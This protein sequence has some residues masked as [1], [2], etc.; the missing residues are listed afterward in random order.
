MVKNGPVALIPKKTKD[1][2]KK[3]ILGNSSTQDV[4]DGL[5]IGI[6][7]AFLPIIGI[8]MYVSFMLTTFLKKNWQIA[9]LSAWISNPFTFVPLYLFNYWVGT[10]F[11]NVSVSISEM[12]VALKNWNW[13][14]IASMSLEVL[15]PLFLG[16]AIVGIV[17]AFISRALCLK[18]YPAIKE[19]YLKKY[20]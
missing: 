5:A 12:E 20:S 13:E 2:F 19:K 10:W 16:S 3:L 17:A 4:A 1:L 6:F 15:E 9:V 7:I 14:A 11:F 18:Y 8:Q